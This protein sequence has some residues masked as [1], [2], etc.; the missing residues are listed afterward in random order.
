VA[1]LH[2]ETRIYCSYIEEAE[3]D[4]ALTPRKQE[5]IDH[6]IRPLA[7][8]YSVEIDSLD[9]TTWNKYLRRFVDANLFQTWSYAET[10][11]GRRNMGHLVLRR[12]GEVVAI[13]QARVRQIP[14]LGVG[15]SYVR[16][17]PLWQLRDREP[18]VEILRQVVRAMRNEYVCRR[19]LALR[20][21][22]RIF[23]DDS[24]GL[25]AILKE[26]GLALVR[27]E[28]RERTLLMDLAPSLA[29]LRDGMP[30]LGRRNLKTAEKNNLE[31]AE[32]C[33]EKLFDQVVALYTETIKRKKFA[34]SIDPE[35]FKRIQALLPEDFKMRVLLCSVQGEPCA[36]IIFSLMGDTGIPMV[37]ATGD[38]GLVCKGSF[39]V[40]WQ[41]IDY[42]KEHGAIVYDLNGINPE[43]NPG[44]YNF[45][46]D[47]AGKHGRDVYY[48]GRFDAAPGP[49]SRLLLKLADELKKRRREW[50]QYRTS[51]KSTQED[52]P[53]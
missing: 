38:A 6:K 50:K 23:T 32:G 22:P 51:R 3:L 30:R 36:G 39:L 47:I 4:G 12:Q 28:K 29:E 9:E 27:E 35:E 7:P 37:A 34:K 15:V 40:Q 13:A 45:K 8:N 41:M 52:K 33:D 24:L 44:T 19:G 46:R 11:E 10:V 1:I 16:S 14:L 20:L 21:Y 48:L 2:I 25:G 53:N 17:G 5:M 42:L 43:K 31:M 26:E 49:I 18:D